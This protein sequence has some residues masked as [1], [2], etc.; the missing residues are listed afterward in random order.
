MDPK[1]VSEIIKQAR[2]AERHRC[3]QTILRHVRKQC[4]G[5]CCDN[6]NCA[7]VRHAL[8]ALGYKPR[9]TALPQGKKLHS[10]DM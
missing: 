6:C 3:V 8:K 10:Q 4:S 9:K 7:G 1:V 5:I 2:A